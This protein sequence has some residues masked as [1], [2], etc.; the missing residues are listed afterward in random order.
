MRRS[1][2]GI[3]V[4]LAL[5]AP[6][7]PAAAEGPLTHTVTYTIATD[8]PFTADIYYRDVQPP[9]YAEYSHNPYV[10]SPK[11]VAE[12]GPDRPWVREVQLADPN[13]WAM[14]VGTSGLAPN[15]PNFHCSLAVDGNVLV[16]NSGAKGALCSLRKW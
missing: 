1:A 13:E 5:T 15:P 10:F 4:V 14:V 2:S 11:A 3:A 6:A 16:T 9:N 7:G 8:I 12:I